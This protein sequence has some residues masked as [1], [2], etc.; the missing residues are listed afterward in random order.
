MF[1]HVVTEVHLLPNSCLP[2]TNKLNF[3]NNNI[4]GT[5]IL[6]GT[7]YST[8]IRQIFQ[9]L[10]G[11]KLKLMVNDEEKLPESTLQ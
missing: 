11:F 8:G 10:I 5:E 3:H 2:K 1:V 9:T 7:R 4:Y 6:H